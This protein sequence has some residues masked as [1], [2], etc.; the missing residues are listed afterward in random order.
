MN[1]LSQ[2]N[3]AENDMWCTKETTGVAFIAEPLQPRS[4]IRNMRKST[5][6]KNPSNGWYQSAILVTNPCINE[7]NG[8][9]PLAL[10]VFIF[11]AD[12]SKDKGNFDRTKLLPAHNKE[13]NKSWVGKINSPGI[14]AGFINATSYRGFSPNNDL[15]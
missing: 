4:T 3:G 6:G 7:V 15:C 13:N 2:K 12:N 14:Y 5:L 8:Q 9:K 1:I 10:L 11:F